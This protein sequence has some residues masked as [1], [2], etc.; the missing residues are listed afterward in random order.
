MSLRVGAHEKH[1]AAHKATSAFEGM[2]AWQ[3]SVFIEEPKRMQKISAERGNVRAEHRAS[4]RIGEQR[5]FWGFTLNG[6]TSL[7]AV[8]SFY[9]LK[10]PELAPNVT[11]GEHLGRSCYGELHPG[12]RLV[13]GSAELRILEVE[14]D[15]VKKVGLRFLPVTLRQ[16]RRRISSRVPRSGTRPAEAA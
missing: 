2:P 11:L 16:A 4:A 9:G 7:E 10:V 3:S 6:N 13:V 5:P 15:A 8:A 1:L 14:K 12:C